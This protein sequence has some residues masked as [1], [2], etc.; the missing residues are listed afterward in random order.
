MV[1][2][3]FLLNRFAELWAGQSINPLRRYLQDQ[4]D[5][6]ATVGELI[7][8]VLKRRTFAVTPP[9]ERNDGL[10]QARDGSRSRPAGELDAADETDRK[11][12]TILGLSA[13]GLPQDRFD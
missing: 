6:I 2:L 1:R 8:P 5:E 12:I 3:E 4:P 9:E 10:V 7:V 11:L 13:R